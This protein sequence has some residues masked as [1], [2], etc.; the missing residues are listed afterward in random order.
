MKRITIL[1]A[2]IMISLMFG[3]GKKKAESKNMEQIQQEVGIPVRVSTVE[4]TTFRK[5]LSYNAS[6]SGSEESTAQAMVSD[7]ITK[8]NAKVGDKVSQGQII[9]SFPAN[10]PAAQWEQASSA[11]NSIKTVYERMQRLFA[12][13]AISQQ[14][15]DNVETQYKV[16]KANLA[17]SEQMI[18]VRAP[19]SGVIT[20]MMVNPSEKVFPGKDLF[21]VAS[22]SGYKAVIMVPESEIGMLKKGAKATATWQ[23][24]TIT[25]RISQISLAMDRDSKAFRVEVLFP[26]INRNISY[27]VTAEIN[28]EVMAKPNVIVVPRDNI[29]FE[30]GNKFVWRNVDN[31]AV[32][33]AIETGLDNSLT[34]E[35]VSGLN[36][37]DILITEGINMLT[38]N[39]KLR[40]IE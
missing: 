29:L 21:T 22:T 35:V 6:L 8:I 13:G 4:T 15:L 19:I 9:V 11:F 12:Q 37:G 40:V 38:E 36:A 2:I 5:E 10:T 16:S 3:C 25:G 7:I 30:N 33:T 28:I 26:G 27:G 23:E 34:F 32:K 24:E 17:S 18:N 14:D 31:K 20:A 39:A 1:I